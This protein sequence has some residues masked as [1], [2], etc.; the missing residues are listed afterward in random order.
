MSRVQGNITV[1]AIEERNSSIQG[2]HT[3]RAVIRD[4]G[5]RLRH[6][7]SSFGR[8]FW[9]N[10]LLSPSKIVVVVSLRD[11]T[12]RQPH[13]V[14]PWMAVAEPHAQQLMHEPAATLLNSNSKDSSSSR[15][16]VQS[17]PLPSLDQRLLDHIRSLDFAFV[18]SDAQH[19]DMPIVYASDGFYSTTGYAADEVIGRNCRFL[20][21]PETERQKVMEIRDAIREDRC[22]QVGAPTTHPGT[23]CQDQQRGQGCRHQGHVALLVKLVLAAGIRGWACTVSYAG[24]PCTTQPAS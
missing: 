14:G 19:P 23:K 22:C 10:H 16:A 13:A 1:M 17:T 12:L 3:R 5:I 8:T 4:T 20:Q 21:G 9:S 24:H 6:S 11:G 15:M 18:I 2:V 7:R